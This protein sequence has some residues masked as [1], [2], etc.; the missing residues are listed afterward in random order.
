[1]H[2]AASLIQARPA[3]VS[4]WPREHGA[5]FGLLLPLLVA[6]WTSRPTLAGWLFT[7][8]ALS[9]FFAHEPLV[10]ILG[11][12]G[13]RAR[14]EQSARAGRWL[15][16]WA[17]LAT[18]GAGLGLLFAPV[19]SLVALALPV[20]GGVLVAAVLVQNR[21]H[22]LLGQLLVAPT[23][24]ACAVPV[25]VAGGSSHGAALAVWAVFSVGNMAATWAVHSAIGARKQNLGALRRLG[26]LGA[27]VAVACLGRLGG[28]VGWR[29]FV[30]AAPLLVTS[31][32]LAGWAPHPRHLRRVGWT[33]VGASLATVAL[34]GLGR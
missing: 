32:V 10:V 33:L 19:P 31:L 23:L 13:A 9:A 2:Q 4:F 3:N 16:G 30:A 12:R 5:L 11:H 29:E 22:T 27:V 20:L 6:H 17:A 18:L 24:A 1:M 25:A 7:L 21:E 14:R 26:P 34:L 15:G 8:A 28:W